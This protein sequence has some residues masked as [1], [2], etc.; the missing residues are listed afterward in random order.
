MFSYHPFLVILL[1]PIIYL[2]NLSKKYQNT[3]SDSK[4]RFS[5]FN[6]CISL[7]CDL[8][9]FSFSWRTPIKSEWS[10][11]SELSAADVS[12]WSTVSSS[13]RSIIAYATAQITQI[14]IHLESISVIQA[15]V[16]SWGVRFQIEILKEHF[17]ETWLNSD[18]KLTF[19][20]VLP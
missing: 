13:E 11:D 18:K 19:L 12:F 4:S 7:D 10:V 8:I 20:W 5:S 1:R 14:N 16:I 6:L 9:S 17:L 15:F 3:T 2:P